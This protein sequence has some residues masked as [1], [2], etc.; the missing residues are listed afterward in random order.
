M[1]AMPIYQLR[2]YDGR[3]A[4]T[5]TFEFFAHDDDTAQLSAQDFKGRGRAEL[6]RGAH[7]LNVWPA[8][9]NRE[10]GARSGW[11]RRRSGEPPTADDAQLR[12]RGA[13]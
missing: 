7:W 9:G 1:M 6:W 2:L 3:D 5:S 11:V 12:A 8:N 4:L 13:R 10:R